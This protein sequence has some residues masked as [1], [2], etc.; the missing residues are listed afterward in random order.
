MRLLLVL[1]IPCALAVGGGLSLAADPAPDEGCTGPCIEYSGSIEFNAGWLHSG[2][3][4]IGDSWVVGPSIDTGFTL[5][6][7]HGFSLVGKIVSEPVL[8]PEPGKN[9]VFSEAG[10]YL[11]VLQV[12]YDL[13]NLSIWGGKIHP[14]FGRA[15]DVA[16]GLHGTD[17]AEN[18][19]LAERLGGGAGFSFEAAG[20][21]NRL[22]ASVFTLDRTIFGE[23]L[24]TNRGRTTLED[25]GA[26]NTA[27]VSSFAVAL[28]GCMGAEIDACYDDGSF[29]YQVAGRYQKGGV[30][31][32]G[33]ELGLVGSVNKA[34]SLGD[35]ATLRLLGEAAG[36]RHFDG[37][38]GYALAI[39]GSGALE[40]GPVTTSVAYS[41]LRN[42]VAGEADT[43][44]HL[45]DATVMYDLGEDVSM[46]GETWSI[47][48]GYTFDRAEGEDSHTIG[49]RLSSEFNGNIPLGY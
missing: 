11:D 10:S 26:G 14:A 32:V 48:A 7:G 23:S 44:E 8:D 49:L 17:I 39:T 47:G 15:W 16:P 37:G 3:P 20:L 18:Y 13:D 5:R 46:V 22:E 28:S 38:P 41:Q 42:F 4:E 9:Q 19:E 25:G 31:T 27:G 29:G 35:E 21:T 36:F 33:D 24:F 34:F 30:D 43:A 2:D 1:T 12:Q 6:P 40:L 45:V